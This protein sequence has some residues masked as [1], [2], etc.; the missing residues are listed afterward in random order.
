MINHTYASYKLA[1]LRR[2]RRRLVRDRSGALGLIPV[3]VHVRLQL[4]HPLQPELNLVLAQYSAAAPPEVHPSS[5]RGLTARRGEHIA[6]PGL[7]AHRGDHVL[8]PGH[9][10]VECQV[11]THKHDNRRR[12]DPLGRIGQ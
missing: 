4:V 6:P 9:L 5:E 1:R 2:R 12:V 10:V 7:A 3:A 8:R 11:Q